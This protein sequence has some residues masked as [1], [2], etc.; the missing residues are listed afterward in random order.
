MTTKNKDAA[1]EDFIR[2]IGLLVRKIRS[3]QTH[4]LSLTQSS[5]ISRLS[6]EGP[7]T[8]AELARLEG[9][10]PQSMGTAIAGLI[11]LDLM[12]RKAHPKDGRQFIV[13]LTAKGMAAIAISRKAKV[14]WLSEALTKLNTKDQAALFKAGEIVK[15][16][17]DLT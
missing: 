1:T 14:A 10:K 6:K 5:V 3:T 11:A 15:R 7:A 17:V 2:A 4:G 12:E 13:K 16:L 8:T 9:V